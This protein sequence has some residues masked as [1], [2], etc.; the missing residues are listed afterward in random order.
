MTH[1]SAQSPRVQKVALTK[2]VEESE[3]Q[4]IVSDNLKHKT[5]L[6]EG[7]FVS[8]R[9]SEFISLHGSHGNELVDYDVISTA[10][11][12]VIITILLK[13][14]LRFS[15]DDLTFELCAENGCQMV[16]VNLTQPANFHR[17]V[18]EGN[19]VI[20]L[21]IMIAQEWLTSRCDGSCTISE[22][23]QSHKNHFNLAASNEIESLTRQLL[24]IRRNGDL[25]SNL[26]FD[27][28]TLQIMAAIFSTMNQL[29]PTKVPSTSTLDAN[30][31]IESMLNY[32]ELHLSQSLSVKQLANQFAM[33]TSSLQRKF[34]QQLG[35]TVSG[36]IR[37]RR[38][39]IA[40]QHLERG[41]VS[42]TEA[43]YDAGYNHPAN[44]TCAFKKS[45]GVPPNELARR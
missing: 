38:L 28:L 9:C 5:P 23:I 41:L 15:Y 17:A 21:N 36:Y 44:F 2:H 22:F 31:S 32:I 24:H 39:D 29:T 13:G 20:K 43:A 6:V 10:P 25:A 34:K 16:M 1:N 19:S 33:S 7:D 35:L 4:M 26:N 8:H 18:R 12:S 45:F 14:K 11:P 30:T 27:S 3:K 37:Q 40:K 42:I